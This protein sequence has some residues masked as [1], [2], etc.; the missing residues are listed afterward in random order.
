MTLNDRLTAGK[1]QRGVTLAPFTT[2]HIGGRAELFV[3]AESETEVADA[4]TYARNQGI[5]WLLLGGGSNVLI[6]DEGVRGLVIRNVSH[7]GDLVD[8]VTKTITVSSGRPLAYLVGLAYRAGMAGFEW[9]TGIP[10]TVGGAIC[11]NAGAYGSCIADSLVQ[12]DLLSPTG[13]IMQVNR[14]FL[15]FTYRDSRLKHEQYVVLNATFRVE[16]GNRDEIRAKM[17]EIFV[18]RSAKHPPPQVGSAGS[19]FKNLDPAPGETRRRPAGAV[20]EQAGAKKVA[21]GGASVYEKHANFIINCG[22]A[23]ARD[24]KALARELKTRVAELFGIQLEEEVI[25]IGN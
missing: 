13:E 17:K 1:I 19:Y 10:G 21:V 11:G 5:P 7:D 3:E 23:T 20:L 15:R 16:P 9:A 22:R 2:F 14:D 18:Q 4:I 6:A 24:V 8:P 12:A 25:Y